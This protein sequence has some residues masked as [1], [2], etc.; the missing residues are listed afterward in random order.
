[1][2][3]N[4]ECKGCGNKSPARVHIEY[5]EGDKIE[6]CDRC[7][8]FHRTS[9]V[10][11]VYFNKPYYDEHLAEPHNPNGY[12]GSRRE[13]AEAMKRLNLREAGD[14]K[15]KILGKPIPYIADPVKRRKFFMDNFGG[16]G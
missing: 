2:E 4:K 9:V 1:M 16:K 11:D 6:V 3:K 13:K 10:P 8:D 12:I 14:K 7:G 5:S 15:N